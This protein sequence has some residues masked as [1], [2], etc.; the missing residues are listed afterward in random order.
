M[1]A[2]RRGIRVPEDIGIAGFDDLEIAQ[3][4]VPALTT[5]R[6]KRLQIGKLSAEM[7]LNRINGNANLLNAM[8]LGYEIIPRNSTAR[9]AASSA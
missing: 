2:W 9:P 5:V 3:Q 8:D 4:M 7:L 6:T 1:R